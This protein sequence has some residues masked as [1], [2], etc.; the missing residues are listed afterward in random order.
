[1]NNVFLGGQTIDLCVPEEKDFAEW[2]SW[3]NDQR[4]TRFLEQGK[5]PNTCQD[6]R[7]FYESAISAGRFLTLIKSKDSELLGIF[8]LSDIDFEKKKCQVAYVCPK[9]T[10]N[11]LL[12]PLE[13]LALGTEHAFLRLG[14]EKVWA[15]HAFPGL[16]KWAQKTEI[17]GYKTDG[18]FLN[19]FRHGMFASD[20]VRTSITKERFLALYK[21][22]GNS[23]WP[24]EDRA[25]KMIG[26]LRNTESLAEKVNLAIQSIHK[27]HEQMIDKIERDVD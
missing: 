8:S 13:A 12:A 24:G 10:N 27:E 19:D 11:T 9:R 4:V 16:L 22:R 14:M 23:L 2:A 15:G 18:V 21:K 5:F 3:F 25:R 20:A 6:Q 17:L 7:K 26:Q 1:M